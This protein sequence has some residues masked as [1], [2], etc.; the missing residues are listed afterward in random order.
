MKIGIMASQISGHLANPPT[1]IDYLV[2]GAGGAGGVNGRGGGAGGEL[3]TS[4]T[5]SI[6]AGVTYTCTIGA[7]ANWTSNNARNGSSSVL[8][9]SGFTT[10]TSLAGQDAGYPNGG[11]GQNGGG[12]GGNY[13]SSNG[14]TGANGTANSLSGSSV[15]YVGGGGGGSNSNNSAAGGSGGGGAG[16][17]VFTG[18]FL[19][20]VGTANTGGGGGG[21]GNGQ[22]IYNV[23]GGSGLIIIRY[24]NTKS[25]AVSTTGS[26]TFS[27]SGGYKRYQFTGSGS[28]TF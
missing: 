18:S 25:D 26:P 19:P 11:V 22:V 12:S 15:T 9:G 23:I 28:I 8:S 21:C 4:N 7:G 24:D 16:G 5:V 14:T 3:F 2:V 20:T 6:S 1:A 13:G 10:V 17:S 27:N